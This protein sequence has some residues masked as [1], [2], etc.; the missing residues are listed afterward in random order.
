MYFEEKG[1]GFPLVLLHGNGED[2]HYF[3]RQ[4]DFF[5][6]YYRVLA[7][8]TPGHGLSPKGE[9]AFTLE[10]FSRDL[11]TLLE[12]QKISGCHLLG[13]SDGGNIALHFALQFPSAVNRLILNGANLFPSGVCERIQ[14]PVV[15][16]YKLCSFFGLF[17]EEAQKK[18][19]I[20]GLMVKEPHFHPEELKK[21]RMPTL[22]LVGDRDMIKEKHSRLIASSLSDGRLKI[23]PG[24]HF[25]AA[26]SPDLY[27][28]T[29]LKF[30]KG[31]KNP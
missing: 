13:F 1:E 18:A 25:L 19:S 23:L 14:L 4:I 2:H 15:L 28:Q 24:S 29:V 7:P 20:L 11:H 21:L 5:S 27:N 9:G 30:L 10:R 31:A 8:D 22:V 12:E 26:E 3:D 17:S 6:R 16:G